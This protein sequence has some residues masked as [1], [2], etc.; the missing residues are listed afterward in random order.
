MSP[1]KP[2]CLFLGPRHAD[3]EAARELK[4]RI[5]RPT[6]REAGLQVWFEQGRS[7]AGNGWQEQLEHALTEQATAFAVYVGSRG[8]INWVDR[9]VR[10]G[11]SR[12][13]GAQA[14]PFI[15]ILGGPAVESAALPPFAQQFQGV[16]DPLGKD[17]EL[18]RLVKAALSRAET[19]NVILTTDPFVGLRAMTEAEADRFFGRDDEI[20]EV[21][22]Q[23]RTHRLLAIV[24]ESGSGKSSLVRAGVVP[25]FRG[26]ALEDLS[27]QRPDDRTWHVVVMRPGSNPLE[28]LR[29]ARDPAER[30]DSPARRPPGCAGTPFLIRAQ[31][32]H[33]LRCDLPV[34]STQTLLVVDQFEG[35]DPDAGGGPRAVHRLPARAAARP[36]AS[37]C[38]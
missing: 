16:R 1:D 10:V 19:R 12:A 15:P 18:A 17:G 21:V 33:A 25:A 8:V 32:R 35:A 31:S 4:R 6:A 34:A 9:E 37:A 2:P 14:I 26:G 29:R 7:A 28:G 24:A 5:L 30:S 20:N 27:R 3:T 23:L 11:L 13:T 38:C 22:E 36:T